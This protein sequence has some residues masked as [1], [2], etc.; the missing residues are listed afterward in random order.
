MAVDIRQ[1]RSVDRQVYEDELLPWLPER[2]IDLHLHVYLEKH[3]DPATP[4]RKA[5][6]WPIEI[7]SQQSFEEMRANFK[8]LFPR[9]RVHGLV[10]ANV[11]RETHIEENNAYVLEGLNDPRNDIDALFVTRPEWDA[12]VITDAM[13]KGFVGIKPYPDLSPQKS[14]EV[15]IFDFLPKTHLAELNRLRGIVMLHLPRVGRLGDPNNIRELLELNDE[16]PDLRL[17]V[18]HVGRAYCMPTLKRGLPPFKDRPGVLFDI[19]ANVNPDVMEYALETVG[20][21]RLHYGSDLPVMLMRGIREYEGENYINFTNGPYSWNKNRKSPEVE[22]RY[23]YFVYEELR[24]L[25][26]AVQR[27]GLGREVVEQIL[28]TNSAKLLQLC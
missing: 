19:T 3:M 14:R 20:P 12:S 21:D 17:V 9:Q 10:F 27:L 25:I 22:A 13:R 4:E 15:G 11:S 26:K 8:M 5:E 1:E 16:F 7:A 18:A 2:I 28:Y 24:A 6:R 23:T